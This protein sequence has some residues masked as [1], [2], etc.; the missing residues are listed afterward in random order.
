MIYHP[1]LTLYNSSQDAGDEQNIV[2]GKTQAQKSQIDKSKLAPVFSKEKKLKEKSALPKG[3]ESFPV[4]QY[5]LVVVRPDLFFIQLER[6]N[7]NL[8]VR[9][10][11]K[12][13]F[14]YRMEN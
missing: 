3:K 10:S 4:V 2:E 9:W 7:L 14:D 5:F 1:K 13:L 11:F 6:Y 8:R 12:H